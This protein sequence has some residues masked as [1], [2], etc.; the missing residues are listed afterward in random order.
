MSEVQNHNIMAFQDQ[1]G[2]V[3]F[4]LDR[5][6]VRDLHHGLEV[7]SYVLAKDKVGIH[8][9]DKNET[10]TISVTETREVTA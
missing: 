7:Q 4:T 3:W 6:K 9:L 8:S 10:R 5:D 1:N 2:A